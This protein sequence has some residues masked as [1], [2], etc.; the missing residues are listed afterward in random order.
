MKVNIGVTEYDIK[1]VSEEEIKKDF[2][3]AYPG[4]ECD[5]FFG[6]TDFPENKVKINNAHNKQ[7]KKQTFWHEVTHAMLDEIGMQELNGDEGFVEAL[8]KQIYG[9]INSNKLDKI[10]AYLGD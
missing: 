4:S 9:V 8:S 2:Q 1:L 5:V 3:D 6:L 10:Y 7:M